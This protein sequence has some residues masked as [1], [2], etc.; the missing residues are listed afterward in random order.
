MVRLNIINNVEKKNII[1]NTFLIS[2]SSTPAILS[3]CNCEQTNRQK[4][5]NISAN[6][7]LLLGKRC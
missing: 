1:I 7:K 2:N 6:I 4:I 3:Q 5:N